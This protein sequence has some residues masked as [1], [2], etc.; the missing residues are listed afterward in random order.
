[1]AQSLENIYVF[2]R[3]DLYI[4]WESENIIQRIIKVVYC[5]EEMDNYGQAMMRL[6]HYF[7]S[8]LSA[9]AK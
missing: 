3:D 5:F 7:N 2:G 1:M 9:L 8:S 6:L 4:A